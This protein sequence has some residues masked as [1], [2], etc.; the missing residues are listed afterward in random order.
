MKHFLLLTILSLIF[1][2]STAQDTVRNVEGGGYLFTINNSI[3]AAPVENQYRSG[4]CWSFFCS[5][6][7]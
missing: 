5:L 4:T 6:I 2:E 3:E 7:L 1:L